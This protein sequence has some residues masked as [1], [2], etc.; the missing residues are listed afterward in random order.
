MATKKYDENQ[1]QSLSALEHIRLRSGMYIGRI[2]N[3][4]NQNDGI[5]VL[6]KEVV[7]NSI[8]EFNENCGNKIEITLK[9]KT[10]TVRDY[11]RGIPLGKVIDCVSKINTG[12][13]YTNEVFHRSVG[14]NGVGTKAV[15]ALSSHFLVKSYRDGKYVSATFSQGKIIDKK[16]GCDKTQLDG[17]FVE[18]TPDSEI[19]K[20]Y[21][22]DEDFIESRLWNYAYLNPGLTLKYNGKNFKST[23]GLLD[24]LD[25]A[26]D[27]NEMYPLVH[28]RGEFLEF[29]MTHIGSNYGETYY[30]YVNGQ[31]TVDG[32]T[33]LS[34][35]K[36]GILKAVNEHFKKSWSAQDV[37][38]GIIGA[39][40]IK[41]E[42]PVFE[43]QTKNKLGNTEIR[44]WV[45]QEVKSGL[46]DFLL[47]NTQAADKLS[48]KID[49][50]E[51]LRKELSAV[52]KSARSSARRVALN[53]PKL[54]DC[55][56]HLGQSAAHADECDE[57]MI[58]LTEGDSASGSITKTRNVKTQ[59]VFSLRGKILNVYNKN[60][61]EI[62]KNAELYNMMKA[63]G[64]EDSLDGLRYGKV[65]IAT[66]ADNDGFHIRNLL[67]TYFLTYFEE[68]V[69]A[70]RL[71]ILETPLFRVR[72]KKQTAYCYS[73]VDRDNLLAQI[74]GAEVTRFK[75]LGE[76]DP[77]EFGYFI[78]EE[79]KLE[80]VS[81]STLVAAQE[82]VKFYEGDNT[83][84]RR[85]FIMENLI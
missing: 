56:Y 35:F 82:A 76:I 27:S 17:T 13:K 39:I 12:A 4:S 46:I 14:L 77:K 52:R 60:K 54:K 79:M 31:H 84:I 18:F 48:A 53:I 72:N 57:S 80:P 51:K 50:N 25:K 49:H 11:G 78:G 38:E 9:D 44:S 32:G 28:Y 24:L 74:R 55:R 26:V 75:G 73:E 71:Y 16:K 33:H 43:S 40:S 6:F 42:N 37:R 66:D 10:V 2:G 68:L 30:S 3:G 47:K 81:I 41:I 85:D 8:D 65:I 21:V 29:A 83:P 70:G 58:F 67:M 34:A 63:L 5:Y 36:E 19:F 7:D 20:T 62:Y 59:A 61:A 22:Y 23:R 69:Q 1:I 64:I 45:V 15:N